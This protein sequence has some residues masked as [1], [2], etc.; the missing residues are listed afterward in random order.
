MGTSART[1]WV[2][3]FP[4]EFFLCPEDMEK[5]PFTLLGKDGLSKHRDD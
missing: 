3:W 2:C 1:P 4:T 5:P